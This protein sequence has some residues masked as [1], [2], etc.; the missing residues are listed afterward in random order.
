MPRRCRRNQTV[1]SSSAPSRIQRYRRRGGSSIPRGYTA[2]LF[3]PPPPS[4]SIRAVYTHGVVVH[5]GELRAQLLDRSILIK[6][7]SAIDTE[8]RRR[9]R[10]ASRRNFLARV[11][12]FN[13]TDSYPFDRSAASFS[14]G[15]VNPMQFPLVKRN[16]SF[17]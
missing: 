12:V 17:F 8:E 2:P 13:S 16:F 9:A 15:P 3:P 4:F 11:V 6:K 14:S 10:R 5:T 7:N 1:S